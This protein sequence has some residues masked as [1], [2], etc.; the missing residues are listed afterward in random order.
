MKKG[1]KKSSIEI[2]GVYFCNEGEYEKYRLMVTGDCPDCLE[3]IKREPMVY[4]EY[5]ASRCFH[6]R[7]KCNGCGGD[8]FRI[9]FSGDY[10][11]SVRCVGCGRDDVVHEG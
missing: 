6:N 1:P 5:L 4:W 11:T 2:G 10:Q 9:W 8:I 7:I 3:M